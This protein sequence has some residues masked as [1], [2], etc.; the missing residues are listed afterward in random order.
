MTLAGTTE[1]TPPSQKTRKEIE[2]Y[3]ASLPPER[4]SEIEGRTQAHGVDAIGL[5]LGN[6]CRSRTW[7]RGCKDANLHRQSQKELIK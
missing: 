5:G 7:C 1:V 3:W 6:S 4:I 2:D